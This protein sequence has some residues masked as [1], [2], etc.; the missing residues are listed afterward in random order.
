[1]FHFVLERFGEQHLS[2]VRCNLAVIQGY[3]WYIYLSIVCY[4]QDFGAGTNMHLLQLRSFL[5]PM[6]QPRL[7][8]NVSLKLKCLV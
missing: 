8:L 1:M 3:T 6:P 7:Q 2:I 4:S 5:I